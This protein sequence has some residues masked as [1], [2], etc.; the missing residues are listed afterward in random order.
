MTGVRILQ[1]LAIIFLVARIFVRIQL[2]TSIAELVDT[3]KH[4]N[5][6]V[7]PRTF[8]GILSDS[9]TFALYTTLMPTTKAISKMGIAARAADPTKR[10]H[11]ILPYEREF[12]IHSGVLGDTR[13]S[14]QK[15]FLDKY[16]RTINE[17]T[18]TRIWRENRIQMDDAKAAIINNDMNLI[19][20]DSLKQEAYLLLHQRLS[21]AKTD[22]SEIAKLR[23]QRIAGEITKHEYDVAISRYEQLTVNELVKIAEMGFDHNHK[24]NESAALTP[25]DQAA[26][27]LLM[28]GLKSGNPM[29][30]LQVLNPT[31]HVHPNA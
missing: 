28:E 17:R 19:S 8:A 13:A 24:G 29:Q 11:Q 3:V 22:D 2:S 31:V 5:V 4:K 16:G 1:P 7:L 14:I 27:S 9:A 18:I 26:L 30:L 23:S 21:R 25:E 15:K 10:G 12:V 6:R 20:G